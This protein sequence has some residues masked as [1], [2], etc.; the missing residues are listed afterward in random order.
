MTPQPNAPE[1]NPFADL[2]RPVIL[3]V[4]P[5]LETGGR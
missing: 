1:R 5:A 3:Q 2:E 4:I